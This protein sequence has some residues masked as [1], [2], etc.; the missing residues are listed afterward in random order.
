MISFAD[1]KFVRTLKKKKA[2]VAKI[3]FESLKKKKK[4]TIKGKCAFPTVCLV[5]C[6]MRFLF[7]QSKW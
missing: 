6:E 2:N 3:K 1:K 4:T 5:L 7:D